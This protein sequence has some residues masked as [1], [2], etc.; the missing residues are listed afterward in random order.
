MKYLTRESIS[1]LDRSG[2]DWPSIWSTYWW[3]LLSCLLITWHEVTTHVTHIIAAME[4]DA[5]H[6]STLGMSWEQGSLH[7]QVLQR[8]A[9]VCTESLW[10][11]FKSSWGCVRLSTAASVPQKLIPIDCATSCLF[12]HPLFYWPGLWVFNI[13]ENIWYLF[14]VWLTLHNITS[15]GLIHAT[16]TPCN[17]SKRE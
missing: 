8:L 6:T 2:N 1:K 13:S 7:I 4:S 5:M 14:C 10:I 11:F 17:M 15:S 9:C 3:E 12:R 16:P